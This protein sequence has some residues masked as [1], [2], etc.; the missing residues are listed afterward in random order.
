MIRAR[1]RRPA[2]RTAGRSGGSVPGFVASLSV[3]VLAAGISMAVCLV[4]ARARDSGARRRP[5]PPP[6]TDPAPPTGI[7][8]ASTVAEAAIA[9]PTGAER[10]IE[11][12]VVAALPEPRAGNLRARLVA[13]AVRVLLTMS[14]VTVLSLAACAVV[15]LLWGWNAYTVTSGSMAPLVRPGD[16]VVA[17]GLHRRQTPPPGSVVV[18]AP[19]RKGGQPITHRIVEHLPDGRYRTKGDANP[20]PDTRLVTPDLIIGNARIV[21][22]MAGQIQLLF[23]RTAPIAGVVVIVLSLVVPP[24]LRRRNRR[25]PGDRRRRGT[26]GPRRRNGRHRVGTAVTIVCCLGLSATAAGMSRSGTR[27]A[28]VGT[29]STPTNSFRASG[30]YYAAIKA[31]L[32]ISYW[33]MGGTNDTSVVDE[34]NR[35]PLALMN[36]PTVGQPGAL[37][38][39]SDTATGFKNS[40]VSYGTV[41]QD[42]Y[43]LSTTMS[44]G[45]WAKSAGGVN[46]RIVVKG[47]S[48][49]SRL[50]Y[51]L[52]WSSNAAD[53]RFVMDVGGAR[54][55]AQSPWLTPTTAWHF[56]VGVYDGSA[57]RLYLDGV[58]KNV[59][60]ATGAMVTD[61]TLPLQISD[62]SSSAMTGQIDEVAVWSTVLSPT[63]IKRFYDLATL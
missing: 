57:V 46:W 39:D 42:V 36:T 27:A 4:A 44:V 16:V 63:D 11:K 40:P 26:D 62:N 35:W 49:T 55:T 23:G 21:V 20:Q 56:V 43:S 25:R 53:M 58:Q 37:L 31:S 15:P 2:D 47:D 8:G 3:V 33:R 61:N 6:H 19:L 18:L 50:N 10:R 5:A 45:V 22:P 51:L 60:A 1:S 34:M 29:T 32:P 59:A 7:A 30:P 12:P 9:P 24:L 41:K 14:M 48:A 13:D 28:W 17:S 52:A 54:K 38:G